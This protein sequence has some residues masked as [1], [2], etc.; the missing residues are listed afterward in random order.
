MKVVFIVGFFTPIEKELRESFPNQFEEGSLI[1]IP[2]TGPQKPPNLHILNSRL[3][4]IVSEDKATVLIVLAVLR[5]KEW[6]EEKVQASLVEA[7][8]RREGNE[9]HL[10]TTPN[11]RDLKLI[12]KTVTEF[13]PSRPKRMSAELIRTKIGLK[14]VHCV[15]SSQHPEFRRIL[16]RRGFTTAVCDEFFEEIVVEYDAK[17]ERLG[18]KISSSVVLLYAFYGIS[19]KTESALDNY[20]GRIFKMPAPVECV[21]EFRKW[22]LELS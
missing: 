2:Q 15:R 10:I 14:K 1:W 4:E 18:E 12:Q 11:A 22:L 13:G 6:L 17:P 7:K 9:V 16:E 20:K 21:E 5:G 3:F 8:A 19:H